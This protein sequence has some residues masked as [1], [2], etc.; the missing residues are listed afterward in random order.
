[1]Y[2]LQITPELIVEINQAHSLGAGMSGVAYAGM[3]SSGPISMMTQLE[4]SSL[5]KES[6]LKRARS[7]ECPNPWS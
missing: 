7:G 3:I 5:P 6:S 1:M 4:P 2:A